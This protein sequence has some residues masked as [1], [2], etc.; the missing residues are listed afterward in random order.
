MLLLSTVGQAL[1]NMWLAIDAEGHGLS[2]FVGASSH[3]LVGQQKQ[4]LLQEC[5][6]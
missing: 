1:R 6:V 2:S 3:A 5:G 4:V